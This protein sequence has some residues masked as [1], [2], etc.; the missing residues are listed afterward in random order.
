MRIDVGYKS[1]EGYNPFSFDKLSDLSQEIHP[2]DNCFEKDS[3]ILIHRYVLDFWLKDILNRQGEVDDLLYEKAK[4][5]DFVQS[6]NISQYPDILD[7]FV[8]IRQKYGHRYRIPSIYD[9]NTLSEE[10]TRYFTLFSRV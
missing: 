7:M 3:D 6:F 4:Q 10:K 8:Y 2:D 1:D 5:L 9:E